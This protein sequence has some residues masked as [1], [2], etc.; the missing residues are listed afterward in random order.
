[1]SSKKLGDSYE[2]TLK[3]NYLYNDKELFDDADLNWYDYG[4]RN[5]DPQIGRFP[6]LDPLTDSYPFLTPYQY[7]GDEPIA[8]VDVDGLEPVNVDIVGKI[9]QIT[10]DG[11]QNVIAKVIKSGQYVGMWSVS[12][13]KDGIICSR[14]FKAT[15]FLT[16]NF[17]NAANHLNQIINIGNAA[18]RGITRPITNGDINQHFNIHTDSKQLAQNDYANAKESLDNAIQ[19]GWHRASPFIKK[20]GGQPL[21]VEGGEVNDITGETRSF[22][23]AIEPVYPEAYLMPVPKLGFAFKW[24]ARFGIEEAAA[25]EGLNLIPEGKLANHLFKGAGKLADNPANRTLI[26]NIANSKALGVDA[27][28]KSWH[29]GLDGAGKSIYTYTQN[30]VVKGAGYATMSAEQMI[31]K[32]GLK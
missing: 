4:F 8:N 19:N 15:G 13:G 2:G 1:L 6:Q 5:Y 10:K 14:V 21:G 16:Q 3:N 23:T 7:A 12:W 22:P 31:L 32:Y 20:A 25:K 27:F 11:G 30:G 9:I 17:I 28:G 29:M 26:Q 24:L 18:L